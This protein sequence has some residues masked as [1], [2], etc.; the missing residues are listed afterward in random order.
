MKFI[1]WLDWERA[2][3][4]HFDFV[5]EDSF[6]DVSARR[7]LRFFSELTQI[8]K[9]SI[10]SQG[11]AYFPEILG[12][13]QTK[14]M[15]VTMWLLNSKGIL[16]H[17]IRD[18]FSAGGT[19]PSI[20]A[21]RNTYFRVPQVVAHLQSS[22]PEIRDTIESASIDDLKISWRRQF[23]NH[24]LDTW[25]SIASRYLGKTV[26]RADFNTERFMRDIFE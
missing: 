10:R 25:I 26:R 22:A 24:R 4:G 3:G 6:G 21:G 7:E 18:L 23:T 13:A 19:V 20:R 5:I 9:S 11:F 8:E 12:T 2:E 17:N 1:E 15:G 16:P 14:Y